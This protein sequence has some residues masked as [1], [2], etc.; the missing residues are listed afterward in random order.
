MVS[1]HKLLFPRFKFA[2]DEAFATVRW[3]PRRVDSYNCRNVRG[4]SSTSLHSYGLAWDFFATDDHVPPPGGVWKPE[5]TV[6]YEFAYCFIRQGFKWGR[7]F[8]RQDWPHIEWADG[9]PGR[10]NDVYHPSPLP[11]G[12]FDM[13]LARTART[14]SWEPDADWANGGFYEVQWDGGVLARAG[15]PFF[16]SYPGLKPE[17]RQ[18]ERGFL[19]IGPRADRQPGYAIFSTDGGVYAFGPGEE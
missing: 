5:N 1:V 18:G 17:Q 9:A 19:A 10:V 4:S 8:N 7:Y 2:C 12:D 3:A 11:R 16:G 14:D 6:P 13:P 15:A